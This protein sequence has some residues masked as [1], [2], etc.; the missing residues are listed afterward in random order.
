MVIHDISLPVSEDLVVWPGDPAIHISQPSHIDKGDKATV[1]RLDMGAHT[2]T[3]VDAPCHF[4][5]GGAGIDSLDLDTL[6]GPALVAEVPANGN[7]SAEVLKG[8]GI[9]SGTQRVLFR[10]R[11]SELWSREGHSFSKEFV[12]ITADGAEWLVELGVRLVGVDYLSVAP[13]GQ[14][15]P[16][17]KTLLQAGVIIV[18][19]LNLSSVQA[20]MY[21]LVCLPLRLVGLDGSPAR[22]ILIEENADRSLI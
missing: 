22:A 7:L 13:F 8:L 5:L 14:S 2:G 6:V 10:T 12:G 20:G 9:P 4:I 17:H 3:H 11:N 1:S 15:G 16:T 19:G 18:E 21:T